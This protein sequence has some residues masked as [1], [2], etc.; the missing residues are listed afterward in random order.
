MDTDRNNF[1]KDLHG[2]RRK[3]PSVL[4]PPPFSA[5]LLFSKL[6]GRDLPIH[7]VPLH[8]LFTFSLYCQSSQQIISLE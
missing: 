4:F 2:G 8:F 7:F 3:V 5:S 1:L 6:R